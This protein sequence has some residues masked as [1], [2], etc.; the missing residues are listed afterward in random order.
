MAIM[1]SPARGVRRP[2]VAAWAA[3]A[4]LCGAPT[5]AWQSKAG[6]RIF[7]LTALH[8]IH[9]TI[10]ATEWSVLMTSSARNGGGTGGTDYRLA[11]GRLIHV[12]SGFGGYFPW[13]KANLRADST[14]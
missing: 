12:G 10:P 6:D 1:D 4:L 9:F 7:G 3:A 2:L 8:Q 14:E 11:D 5:N 13:V